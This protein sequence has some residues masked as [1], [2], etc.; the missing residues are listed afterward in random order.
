LERERDYMNVVLNFHKGDQFSAQALMELLMVVDEGVDCNYYVQY[1]DDLATIQVWEVLNEFLRR[2][3]AHL[4]TES[5]EIR[6]PQAMIE[7]DPNLLDY[8]GN[9]TKRSKVQKQKHLAWNLCVFKHILLLDSFLMVEPDSVVLKH[10]WLKDIHTEWQQYHGPIMG[11]LKTGKIRNA[12]VPTHWAGSSVYDSRQ[13]RAL[14]LRECFSTRYPNP[15][16]K[17]RNEP[18]T[19]LANNCFWGPMFSGYDVSYDYFLFGLYWKETTGQNDPDQWPLGQIDDKQHLIFCDFNSRLGADEI[20]HRFAG[21]LPLMHGV[22][23]DEIRRKMVRHFSSEQPKRR[24]N[25]FPGL[26][27]RR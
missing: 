4:S 13:L 10:G 21:R 18:G 27:H 3:K 2:K 12:Y 26:W 23:N 20:F 25:W 15:W 16:W 11:H 19:V 5:P 14:P 24:H 7:D 9:H 1:G 8:E 6:V 22:K 17:Y